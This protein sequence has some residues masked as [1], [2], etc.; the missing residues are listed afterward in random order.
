[1]EDLRMQEDQKT[2]PQKRIATETFRLHIPV[3]SNSESQARLAQN[4]NQG[5][6][7]LE[8]TRLTETGDAIRRRE[9]YLHA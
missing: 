9:C 1:M 3:S 7:E 4:L 6:G 8:V 5:G 2:G